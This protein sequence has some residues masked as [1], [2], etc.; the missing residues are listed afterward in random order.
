MVRVG[1]VCGIAALVVASVLI[2]GVPGAGAGSASIT[3]TWS[4]IM[5][6]PSS[7]SHA[8]VHRLT[9]TVNR[10]ETAGT[11]VI[12]P[13]CRGTLRLHDISNGYHHYTEIA[14][15]GTD[16]RGGGVDCL[17]RVGGGV[18]DVFVSRPG[19]SLD[20]DGTLHRA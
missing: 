12:G 3:G 11:W 9:V 17:E 7:S 6:P 8:R 4:G 1:R 16:C 2:V 14:A 20:S 5:R 18:Q 10:R 15:P 19:T 13:K